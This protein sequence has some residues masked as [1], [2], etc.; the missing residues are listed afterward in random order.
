M[1]MILQ[2]FVNLVDSMTSLKNPSPCCSQHS[3]LVRNAD[4]TSICCIWILCWN[5]WDER[6]S[7]TAATLLCK[8]RTPRT[9]VVTWRFC[10]RGGYAE[11]GAGASFKD[12]YKYSP[13][14]TG[15]MAGPLQMDSW[16]VQFAFDI[17]WLAV[18]IMILHTYTP[19]FSPSWRRGKA[20]V[21]PVLT[22]RQANLF[23]LM[24]FPALIK[25]LMTSVFL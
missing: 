4:F 10:E 1:L 15:S 13:W 6:R 19:S 2:V 12:S 7:C 16:Y 5:A 24:F 23:S 3:F 21:F 11:V 18:T 25:R 17:S 8:P 9:H 20:L 14:W 22:S